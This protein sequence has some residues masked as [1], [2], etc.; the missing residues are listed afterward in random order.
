MFSS[1]FGCR[2]C[3]TRKVLILPD[4]CSEEFLRS[5]GVTLFSASL[6][7]VLKRHHSTNEQFWTLVPFFSQPSGVLDVHLAEF[8]S[9]V[10][11]VCGLA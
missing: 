10:A 6:L 3:F 8:N 2:V 1:V 4:I 5:E 9:K 7:L 11:E